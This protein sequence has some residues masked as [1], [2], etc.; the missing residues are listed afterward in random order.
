MKASLQVPAVHNRRSL[1]GRS[2]PGNECVDTQVI[3]GQPMQKLF[4]ILLYDQ[5]NQV[6]S[7]QWVRH[8][9]VDYKLVR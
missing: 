9:D 7:S 4:R 3:P 6:V 5:M 2:I 1:A 8:G